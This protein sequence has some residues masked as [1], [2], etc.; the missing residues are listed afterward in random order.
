MK[1]MNRSSS[2]MQGLCTWHW[3]SSTEGKTIVNTIGIIFKLILCGISSTALE[4]LLTLS[5]FCFLIHQAFQFSN[6]CQHWGR[7]TYIWKYFLKRSCNYIT[8]N[9]KIEEEGSFQP[10]ASYKKH[11]FKS[12]TALVLTGYKV[13]FVLY[14]T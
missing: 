9:L 6:T 2:W 3:H 7:E 12:V 8:L 4:H 1:E 11:V 5:G 10:T 13:F 14:C